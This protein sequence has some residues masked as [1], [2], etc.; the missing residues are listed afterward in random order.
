MYEAEHGHDRTQ[1]KST[2]K[3]NVFAGNLHMK[4]YRDNDKK[5]FVNESKSVEGKIL[6]V[7]V[8]YQ[9]IPVETV[10]DKHTQKDVPEVKLRGTIEFE[11]IFD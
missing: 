5:A 2:Y 8:P 9:V 1:K 10:W 4:V 6:V 11:L 7:G 3:E